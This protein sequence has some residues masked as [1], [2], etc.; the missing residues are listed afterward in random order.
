MNAFIPVGLVIVLF[1]VFFFTAKRIKLFQSSSVIRFLAGYG[2]VLFLFFVGY[3]LLPETKYSETDIM[4]SQEL[5]K[6]QLQQEQLLNRAFNGNINKEDQ[7]YVADR[8]EFP[9]VEEDLYIS[10]LAENQMIIAE[11]VDGLDSIEVIHY[12]T[13]TFVGGIDVTEEV[14]SPTVKVENSTLLIE[15]PGSQEYK[16]KRLTREFPMKQFSEGTKNNRLEAEF[17]VNLLYLKIP[18]DIEVHKDDFYWIE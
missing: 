2:L 17:G 4:E 11:R 12:K 3:L 6:L 18:S 16:L 1:L 5:R 8:W 7:K 10:N 14:A 9:Y 13:K 15:V